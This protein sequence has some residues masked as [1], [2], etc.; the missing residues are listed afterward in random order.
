MHEWWFIPST[1]V[2]GLVRIPGHEWRFFF[3]NS[4]KLDMKSVLHI[5][6]DWPSVVVVH[7][8]HVKKSYESMKFLHTALNNVI[9]LVRIVR[10]QL[11]YSTRN[12][13]MWNISA[14][15]VH[16]RQSGDLWQN[17]LIIKPIPGLKNI[18]GHPL[19]DKRQVALPTFP[20]MLGYKLDWS[21]L[22]VFIYLFL[23]HPRNPW[24]VKK[25]IGYTMS[26]KS[27]R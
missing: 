17:G 9:V 4:S 16:W 11:F 20:S 1:S 26:N 14:L 12:L 10:W 2:D 27:I 19:V 8:L 7:A 23:I 6:K 24:E 13:F 3:I 21:R 5:G 22:S 25:S 18:T 15:R